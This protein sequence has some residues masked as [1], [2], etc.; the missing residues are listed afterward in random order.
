M[1]Q[2]VWQ[3][4]L[5]CLNVFAATTHDAFY[6]HECICR[7]IEQVLAGSIT[8]Q[9]LVTGVVNYRWQDYPALIVSQANSFRAA[10]GGHQGI[11]GAKVYANSKTMLMRS[12]GLTRFC[13]L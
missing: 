1:L 8:D 10:H 9:N 5:G 11:S 6:R 12:S 4:V 13:D 2:N 7:I 3:I